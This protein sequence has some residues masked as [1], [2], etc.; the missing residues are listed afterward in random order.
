MMGFAVL[1]FETEVGFT[2]KSE[3]KNTTA[4]LLLCCGSQEGQTQRKQNVPFLLYGEQATRTEKYQ[5]TALREQ[6]TSLVK[7]GN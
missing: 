3:S 7:R 4:K 6:K 2:Q 5:Q 1:T